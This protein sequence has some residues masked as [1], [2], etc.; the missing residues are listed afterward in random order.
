MYPYLHTNCINLSVKF[1]IILTV[2]P[3]YYSPTYIQDRNTDNIHKTIR[4]E[5]KTHPHKY[6]KTKR[7]SCTNGCKHIRI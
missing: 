6:I 1:N 4:H 5:H 2:F 7:S 3:A